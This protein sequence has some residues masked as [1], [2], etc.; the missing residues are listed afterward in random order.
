MSTL[1]EEI[2]HIKA[3]DIIDHLACF[4]WG[5]HKNHYHIDIRLGGCSYAIHK[6]DSA[7][8]KDTMTLPEQGDWVKQYLQSKYAVKNY[9]VV[10]THWHLDHITEN[11]L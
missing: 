4:Y 9:T 8:I 2:D 10:N 11:Y 6:A 5:R 1:L 3:I 7:I